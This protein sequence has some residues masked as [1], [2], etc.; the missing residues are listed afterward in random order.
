MKTYLAIGTLSGKSFRYSDSA[1]SITAFA[2]YVEQIYPTFEIDAIVFVD[3][4]VDWGVIEGDA[5]AGNK[6]IEIE[7]KYVK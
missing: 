6:P 5:I 3:E 7:I 1:V 2:Q 4:V